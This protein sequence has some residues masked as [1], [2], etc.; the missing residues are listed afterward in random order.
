VSVVILLSFLTWSR[1]QK[2]QNTEELM[3]D[4]MEKDSSNC[5]A[6]FILGNYYS[7]NGRNDKAIDCYIKCIY[8]VNDYSEAYYNLGNV[9][10]N[11][12][13]LEEAMKCYLKAVENNP[14]DKLAY[15]NLGVVYEHMGYHE[16]AIEYYKVSARMG[17]EPAQHVLRYYGVK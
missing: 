8:I 1:A 16:K 11:S 4:V 12:G 6:Y 5:H 13:N 3:N 9:Y 15:N 14:G 17:Y 7:D 2:W 10:F